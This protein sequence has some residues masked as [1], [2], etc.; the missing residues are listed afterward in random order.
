M[1][2]ARIEPLIDAVVAAL[3]GS[4]SSVVACYLDERSLL[5]V[6]GVSGLAG[7]Y[8]G[9]E[10]ICAL[11]DRMAATTEGTLS[12]ETTCTTVASI[13]Q[14]RLCGNVSGGRGGRSLATTATLETKLS[15]IHIREAWLSCADQLAWDAFWG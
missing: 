7:D 6:P 5:H 10:A 11:L 13:G 8:E 12:F 3:A 14:V 15:G 9:R 4:D 1:T 2:P